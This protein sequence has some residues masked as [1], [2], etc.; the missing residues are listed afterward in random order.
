[1]QRL[2]RIVWQIW[3]PVE[4]VLKKGSG[5][6]QFLLP[7]F[8]FVEEV[9]LRAEANASVSLNLDVIQMIITLAAGDKVTKFLIPHGVKP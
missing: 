5:W 7:G 6:G 1:M 9:S 2:Y 3:H 4:R 8:D